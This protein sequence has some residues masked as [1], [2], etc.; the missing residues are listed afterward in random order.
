MHLCVIRS[1]LVIV[2]MLYASSLGVM[3]PV[4]S[5]ERGQYTPEWHN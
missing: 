3:E 1:G 2:A 4:K 5:P